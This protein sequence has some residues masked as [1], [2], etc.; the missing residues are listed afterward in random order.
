MRKA[1]LRGAAR[2]VLV[3]LCSLSERLG[4]RFYTVLGVLVALAGGVAVA[5]NLTSGMKH[6]AFDLIM[7]HRFRNPP[8]DPSIVIVDIDE[9]ALAA[10]ASEYGRWPWPRSVLA[11]FVQG[12]SPQK[13]KAIV[14]DITFSD[15]DVY[16][17]ESD[18][19]FGEAIAETPNTFFPMIRLNPEND[20][21]SGLKLS[22]LPGVTRASADASPDATIAVTL[23]Y[24][25]DLL[26]DHRLGTNNLYADDDGIVRSYHVYREVSGWRVGSLPANLATALG[27]PLPPRPD[28]LLN[29]RGKP[30][31]YRLVSF[32]EVFFDLLKERRTRPQT[33]FTGKIVIIGSTA[34]SLFDLKPT[35]VARIH[36]GVE[37][38][39]TAI[40]NMV[41]GD[42][43]SE[44]RPAVH[45]LVTVLAVSLLG[46]AFTRNI[47]PA[48]LDR[49]FTILQG[50][51]V[52]VTYLF[53]N[54][55]SIF[56][57]LTAPFTLGLLYFFVARFNSTVLDLRKNGHPYLST[58]LDEGRECQGFL[59]QCR[60]HPKDAEARRRLRSIVTRNVGL[61]R[62]GAASPG[63]FTASPLFHAFFR[64]TLLLHWVAPGELAASAL[65]DL[66][67]VAERIAGA[68]ARPGGEGSGITLL[69]HAY[70]FRVDSGGR[71]RLLGEKALAD[72]VAL[73]AG[74][75]S[76]SGPTTGSIRI[77]TS[78]AF[79]AFCSA[80]GTAD[81]P[82]ALRSICVS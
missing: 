44:V 61:S 15:P 72:T 62:Y 69:V 55:S 40:D 13:P 59:V 17:A 48:L 34:P 41:N 56:M 79:R 53:L 38:L 24:L 66:G 2:S 77:V 23:P 67:G 45:L 70:A 18:R 74:A 39:A 37:I 3:P 5:S 29:W 28:V 63:L 81:L 36:P 20:R 73:S 51:L 75:D 27:K 19:F 47:D 49:A 35:S 26:D 16:N 31:A 14:F 82:E 57:D 54:Y 21:L 11:E 25:A 78:D 50:G 30:G 46:V 32:H 80:S 9:A 43:L 1:L 4:S 33:E 52:A 12:I 65:C 68:L 8:P 64:D 42:Y 7:K 22:R 10:M 58:V 60:L 76:D 6:Q 71:W